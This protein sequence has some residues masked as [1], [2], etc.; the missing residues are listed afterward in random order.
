MKGFTLIELM[1][2]ITVS[3]FITGGIIVNYNAYNQTQTLKQA[4]LTLKNDFRYIQSKAASGEKPSGCATLTGWQITFAAR[5]YSY[6]PVCNGNPAGTQS[7]ISLP[8]GISFSAVP[9]PATIVIYV[10]SQGTSLTGTVTISL[11]GSG[12][13]YTLKVNPAGNMGDFGINQ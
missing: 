10:L 12:K 5:S 8:P 9:S 11:T 1:V 4:A 13:T 3:L 7:S 2:A 6:Q